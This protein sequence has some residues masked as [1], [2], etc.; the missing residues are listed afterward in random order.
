MSGDALLLYTDGLV[1]AQNQA[2]EMFGRE[3]L[4]P[5]VRANAHLSAQELCEA[6]YKEMRQF[7]KDERLVDDT[8]IVV[9]KFLPP[10]TD[11]N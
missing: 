7:T 6:I 9:V 3:R 2:G 10:P 8:T 11:E 1:E 5:F 4:E